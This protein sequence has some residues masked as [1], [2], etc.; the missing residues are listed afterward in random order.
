LIGADDIRKDSF[1]PISNSFS[2]D[3][4]SDITKGYRSKFIRGGGFISFGN[5]ADMG[6]VK[7]FRVA[8]MVKNMENIRSDIIPHNVPVVMVK[9]SR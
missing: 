2:D 1:E 3:F 9:L 6:R 5:E 4:E 8:F 7:G